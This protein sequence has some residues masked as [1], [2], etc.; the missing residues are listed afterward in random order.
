MTRIRVT[1]HAPKVLEEEGRLKESLVQCDKEREELERRCE[2][3][4]QEQG[5]MAQDIRYVSPLV[6][7]GI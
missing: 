2:G 7:Q 1:H 4:L 5:V 6:P 3:L